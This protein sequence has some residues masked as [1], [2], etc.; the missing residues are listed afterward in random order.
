MTDITGPTG[1]PASP[2]TIKFCSNKHNFKQHRQNHRI[3]V[4]LYESMPWV[5]IHSSHVR[6]RRRNRNRIKI[7]FIIYTRTTSYL[8]KKNHSNKRQKSSILSPK[9]T[10]HPHT[11]DPTMPRPGRVALLWIKMTGHLA[12]QASQKSSR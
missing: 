1:K 2:A 4:V 7:D 3:R 8:T 9:F 12:V 5:L 6:S 10:H 11:I